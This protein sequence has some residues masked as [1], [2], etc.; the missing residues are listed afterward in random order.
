VRDGVEDP[1]PNEPHLG[2]TATIIG[3]RWDRGPLELAVVLSRGEQRQKDDEG[4]WFDSLG[5]EVFG[6]WSLDE[7]WSVFGGLN[8]LEP[9]DD[10]VDTEYRILDY[11]IGAAYDL[12]RNVIIS[13]ELRL[14]E[15]LTAAGEDVPEDTTFSFG[16]NLSW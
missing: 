15:S 8:R 7:H 4:I 16:V 2:D 12:N 1:G 10:G 13:G 6:Q 5:S 14:S 11:L 9:D 3:A